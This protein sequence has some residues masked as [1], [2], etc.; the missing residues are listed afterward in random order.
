MI[1]GRELDVLV[2]EKVFKWH[3]I[4]S[5]AMLMDDG[6]MGWDMCG[7]YPDS[8]PYEASHRIPRYSTSIAAAWEVMEKLAK[9]GLVLSLERGDKWRSAFRK[10]LPSYFEQ[11]EYVVADTAPLAI[12][13]AALKAVSYEP[14]QE[15]R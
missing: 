4:Q 15:T 9:D 12:C 5:L 13:L 2:A 8:P 7:N 14:P 6:L 3:N 11:M 10:N 1:A